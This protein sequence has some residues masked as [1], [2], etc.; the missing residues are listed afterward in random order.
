ML[1][2]KKKIQYIIDP[3]DIEPEAKA[4]AGDKALPLSFVSGDKHVVVAGTNVHL[5]NIGA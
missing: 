5:N 4:I 3:L 2:K 1:K